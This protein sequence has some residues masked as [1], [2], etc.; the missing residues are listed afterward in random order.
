MK[1]KGNDGKGDNT[2]RDLWNNLN[3]QYNFTFDC[4]ANKDNTKCYQFSDDFKEIKKENLEMGVCWMNPPFSISKEMFIHF[5][6]VVNKGVAIYR[7]DNME[8]QVWQDMRIFEAFVFS[9]YN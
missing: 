3:K 1:G 4:C 8:T 6:N 7:C 2:E 9:K 5:F